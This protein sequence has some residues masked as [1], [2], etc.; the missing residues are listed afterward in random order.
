MM[1]NLCDQCS[2]DQH[3]CKQLTGLMLTREEYEA[4]FK[5]YEENLFVEE[6]DGVYKV[7]PRNGT[8]CPHWDHGGCAIYP[9]RPID[10]RLYPYMMTRVDKGK[11][12][13]KVTLQMSSQC[14]KI[15]AVG[16]LKSETEAHA[17]ATEF[18]RKVTGD[19]TGIIVQRESRLVSQLRS[20][21]KA[22]FRRD[23][24]KP[25]GIR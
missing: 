4:Q 19:E 2:T 20:W 7:T 15:D 9:N 23:R 11:D 21:I 5:N 25:S 13:L 16:M 3:C 24:S 17:L 14:P 12:T 1:D 6:S 22:I 18:W 10:C 8:A